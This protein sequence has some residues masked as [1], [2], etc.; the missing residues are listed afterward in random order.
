MT[1]PKVVMAVP[2]IVP[3]KTTT[4]TTITTMKKSTGKPQVTSST[5]VTSGPADAKSGGS[6]AKGPVVVKSQMSSTY[7]VASIADAEALSKTGFFKGMPIEVEGLGLYN[8]IKPKAKT[9]PGLK[10]VPSPRHSYP[11]AFG[12]FKPIPMTPSPRPQPSPSSLLPISIAA[13]TPNLSPSS[14]LRPPPSPKPGPTSFQKPNSAPCEHNFQHSPSLMRYQSLQVDGPPPMS[15][16][17]RSPRGDRPRMM[18]LA[19]VRSEDGNVRGLLRP[20]FRDCG[21]VHPI[22]VALQ[23][24]ASQIA[25]FSETLDRVHQMG[26]QLLKSTPGLSSHL[27]PNAIDYILFYTYESYPPDKSLYCL[28]SK[29]LRE[30]R[31]DAII[32]W[33]D[34]IWGLLH[35]LRRLPQS[36]QRLMYRGCK[37][38]LAD[39]GPNYTKGEQVTWYAFSS[40]CDK[41]EVQE[42]FT[43][44]KGDRV[45]FHLEMRS[46]IARDISA[47]SFYPNEAE[48]LLPPGVRFSVKSIAQLGNGLTMVQMEEVRLDETIVDLT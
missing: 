30:L 46:G 38:T 2:E 48:L 24:V 39:F 33:V 27:D 42:T 8:D 34:Y 12:V 9:S 37:G 17:P 32:P 11:P 28:M 20:F 3:K 13:C 23:P 5:Q 41:L 1:A 21:P 36:R 7:I 22:G 29:A 31:R 45:M 19:D 25:D 47:L 4:T 6:E 15:Q 10:P 16:A 44:D 43:G 35:S 26:R 40:C 18:R 14:G